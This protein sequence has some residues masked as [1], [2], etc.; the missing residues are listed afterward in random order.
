[1]KKTKF[2]LL[3]YDYAVSQ[4][5]DQEEM[6]SQYDVDIYV[7]A[8]DRKNHVVIDEHMCELFPDLETLGLGDFM[9]GEMEG[10]GTETGVALVSKLQ[11]LGFTASLETVDLIF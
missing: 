7:I 5:P 3:V 4:T 11:A 8:Y 10:D 6:H 9:E 2:E 1:M